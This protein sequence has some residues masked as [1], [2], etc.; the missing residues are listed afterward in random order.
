MKC[1]VSVIFNFQAMVI[2]IVT[3]VLPEILIEERGKMGKSC[4]VSLMAF[5]GDVTTM[6]SLK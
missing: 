5:F 6:T 1:S 4:D 2:Y 3:T